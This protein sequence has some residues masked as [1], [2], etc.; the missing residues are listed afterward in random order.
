VNKKETYEKNAADWMKEAKVRISTQG[1][2][3]VR[4]MP[5]VVRY[6]VDFWVTTAS[7]PES[8]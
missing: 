5:R 6:Q 8:R 4:E 3:H 2:E 7:Q 1:K